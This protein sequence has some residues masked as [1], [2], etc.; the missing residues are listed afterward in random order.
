MQQEK[1]MIEMQAFEEIT[2]NRMSREIRL[3]GSEGGRT[4]FNRPS[5]PLSSL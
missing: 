2:R 3:S 1:S 4:E 5:L